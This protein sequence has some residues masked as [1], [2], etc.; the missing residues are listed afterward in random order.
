MINGYTL[1]GKSS[2]DASF[3]NGDEPSGVLCPRCGSCLDYGYSPV[4]LDIKSSKKYDVSYTNDLR[5]LYSERFFVFCRDVLKADKLFKPVQVRDT[6]L[7]YM[8]PSQIVEFDYI[9]RKTRFEGTCDQCGGY[10]SVAGAHPAFLKA[11][12]PV[13]S[14]F[15][16][17]D[18]AFG[19]GKAKF[20]L[21]IIGSEWKK[22]LAS[23]KFRGIDFGEVTD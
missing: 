5:K 10:S 17:T 12:E 2:N 21:I 18:I 14:G 13:G 1:S 19:S 9:R 11:S 3:F 16:R 23:E 7:Y 4:S 20:P 15:F 8:F 6:V 22:L